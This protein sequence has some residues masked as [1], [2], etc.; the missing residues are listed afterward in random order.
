MLQLAISVAAGRAFV[1]Q[2]V[3]SG[4]VIG[5][6]WEDPQE[7]LR[8]RLNYVLPTLGVSQASIEGK[9]IL[10][11]YDPER[12]PEDYVLWR[13][14]ARTAAFYALD[15]DLAKITDPALLVVDTAKIAYRDS[16]VDPEAVREFIFAL[17]SLAGRHKIAIVLITHANRIG[18]TSGTLEWEN[19]SRSVF[20][21]VSRNNRFMLQLLK[22]NYAAAVAPIPMTRTEAGVWVE[23]KEG[24][25]STA[26]K[27][28]RQ[29][30]L[31]SVS[32]RAREAFLACLDEVSHPV[33][34]N[35]NSPKRNFAPK[36]FA[37]MKIAKRFNVTQ[38]DLESAMTSLLDEGE[39]CEKPIGTKHP[40][41]ILVRA[42]PTGQS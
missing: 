2:E 40:T 20:H 27:A 11:Y 6:F 25:T 1:S 14:G 22:T 8:E 13:D 32:E 3:E 38:A 21:I 17:R 35:R 4:R 34:K 5:L 26:G 42:R 7:V 31:K 29:V 28:E 37:T 9:L 16:L 23:D 15:N 18:D 24:A 19:N 36:V 41:R 39:I 33:S 30:G 12:D 10:Q